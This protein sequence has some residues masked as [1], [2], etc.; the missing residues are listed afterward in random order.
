MTPGPKKIAVDAFL[1]KNGF[2]FEMK[3][4][5]RFQAYDFGIHQSLYYIDVI[6]QANR[7]IDVIAIF[8]KKHKGENFNIVFPIECKFAPDPWI[9][10]SS[11]TKGFP[12]CYTHSRPAAQWIIHLAGVSNWDSFFEVK[13]NIGYGITVA[14]KKDNAY[15]GIQKLLGFLK[16]EQKYH[17]FA[18][19]ND[20]TIYIPIIALRGQLFKAQLDQDEK[21]QTEEI[22]E[23]QVFYKED[24]EGVIPKIHIVTESHLEDYIRQLV[25]DC[26][27]LFIEPYI[28]DRFLEEYSPQSRCL[29]WFPKR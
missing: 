3:V 1:V 6:T 25:G 4:A 10:F 5:S 17:R 15:E 9:L 14:D 11:L 28:K 16:S 8:Y 21:I 2:P 24:L 23:A 29:V 26:N 27:R 22:E 13:R 12:V 20:H 7:E 19:S 18:N